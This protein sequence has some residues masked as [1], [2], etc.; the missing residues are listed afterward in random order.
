MQEKNKNDSFSKKKKK[1]GKENE[2]NFK[3][4]VYYNYNESD[5]K[6]S[7]YLNLK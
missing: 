4:I 5:Y 7:D 6:R 3:D 1:I 2:K